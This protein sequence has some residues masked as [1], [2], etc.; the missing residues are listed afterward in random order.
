M[1]GDAESHPSRCARLLRRQATLRGAGINELAIE[2]HHHCGHTLLRAHRLARGWTLNQAIE[3]IVSE[4]GQG[5]SLVPSRISRWERGVDEPSRRYRDALCRVYRSDP[6]G[7][8]L[9]N[10]YQTPDGVSAGETPPLSRTAKRTDIDG[11]HLAD[12]PLVQPIVVGNDSASIMST[13]ISAATLRRRIDTTLVGAALPELTITHLE[14]VADQYGRVYK[15]LPADR[16]LADVLVDLEQ[17][18]LFAARN[19]PAT[20]RRDLC[21][22]VARLAGLVSMTMVN[23]GQYRE[24]REWA[25]SAR[26][27]ADETGDPTLRAWVAT[28]A[29]VAH[30][31]F[32]D[33][34][35]ALVAA[36]DAELLTRAR[37]AGV[38][39]MAWAIIARAAGMCGDPTTTRRALH[40]ATGL[41][42]VVERIE[43]NTAYE[44][45]TG[46]LHFFSSDALTRLGDT[47]A[48]RDAQDSALAT[49]GPT[50]RL[51]PTLVHLDRAICMIRDGDVAGGVSY[52]TGALL[53]LPGSYRPAIVTRRADAVAEAVPTRHRRLPAVRD[54][55]D[56][57]AQ[58]AIPLPALAMS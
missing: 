31:H 46:Q 55:H 33:P 40:R 28:R 50:E 42:D 26:L 44:F 23:L 9:A 2:I 34:N 7:L 1:V 35:A 22:V 14:T 18:Q 57:L 38:T 52:A 21:V 48:A 51:D 12:V 43:V 45:T 4:C 15:Q 39:A 10:A 13:I 25:H 29:A 56:V 6:V 27:S 8:G 5:E 54:L 47:R 30:L 19:L 20:Q 32:G 53:N 17:M 58:S 11:E 24:A 41:F 3:K 36:R 37:P 16:F 49:F